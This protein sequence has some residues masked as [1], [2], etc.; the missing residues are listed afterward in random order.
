MKLLKKEELKTIKQSQDDILVRKSNT[1]IEAIN[2]ATIKLNL[3]EENYRTKK[4]EVDTKLTKTLN[5]YRIQGNSLELEVIKLEK[6]KKKALKPLEIE[7]DK[8]LDLEIKLS[9]FEDKLNVQLKKNETTEKYLNDNLNIV[10]IKFRG[11]A[12]KEKELDERQQGVQ[13]EENRIKLLEYSLIERLTKFNDFAENRNSAFIVRENAIV[14]KEQ[15]IVAREQIIND[16]KA[17]LD[18]FERKLL[19]K[20]AALQDA[21]K[22]LKN[23]DSR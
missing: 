7:R 12:L 21:K 6:R 5:D 16:R 20:E 14:M 18:K 10:E 8:L 4:A 1:L 23:Y 17:D 2:K 13:M 15:E 11:I 19:S 3:L 22:E 9:L